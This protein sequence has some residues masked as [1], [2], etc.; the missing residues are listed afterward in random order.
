MESY[1]IR[2]TPQGVIRDTFGCSL[3]PS[4]SGNELSFSPSLGDTISL[5]DTD[6]PSGS[7]L[8]IT[9]PETLAE[10]VGFSSTQASLSFCGYKTEAL[11][12]R[13]GSYLEDSGRGNLQVSSGIVSARLSLTERVTDLSE[14]V[15]MIFIKNQV[16]YTI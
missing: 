12:S 11:F 10:D 15:K 4:L 5:A 14:N 7:N 8:T 2:Q 16:H 1:P 3:Y 13:R 6:M 9:L